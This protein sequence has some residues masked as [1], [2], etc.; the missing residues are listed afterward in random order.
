[1]R[2]DLDDIKKSEITNYIAEVFYEELKFVLGDTSEQQMWIKNHGMNSRAFSKDVL[3]VTS[4]DYLSMQLEQD[5]IFIHL[6]RNSIYHQLPEILFHPLVIS[7]P[8]MSNSEVVDAIRENKKKQDES[9]HFFIPFDTQLFEEKLKL[10]NRHLNIFTDPYAQKNL[11]SLAKEVIDKEI[12]LTKEQFYKLFLNLCNAEVLKENLPELE[13]LLKSILGVKVLLKY[14]T[15]ELEQSP[16][17]V[18]GTGVLGYT[19]GT[20]G[21]V[22]SE[23]DDICASIILTKQLTYKEL[24]R[25][26]II[27]VKVLEFF[28]FANREIK[29]VYQFTETGGFTLGLNYLG[30]DTIPHQHEHK[31]VEPKPGN[32]ILTPQEE[33]EF[34]A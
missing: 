5:A 13:V 20:Q 23:Q 34:I 21:N 26:R 19:F 18:L 10:S 11:F 32:T 14:Q 9:I 28:V 24:Q 22:I 29:V 31:E 3:D 15:C 25:T 17:E 1:M 2:A 16:F 30:Y 7:N 27:I 6:S 33:L 4:F 12:P 8:S